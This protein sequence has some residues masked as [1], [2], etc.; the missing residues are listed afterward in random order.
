MK[1]LSVAEMVTAEAQ[2]NSAGISYA[3]MMENAGKAVAD[4]ILT[5]E[6][7]RHK[8]VTVLVGAGN[9]GGD[10]LVAARHL[11]QANVD[12]VC[13]LYKPRD[14]EQEPN[15][16]KILELNVP[17]FQF[18]SDQQLRRLHGRLLRTDIVVD[19]LLGTGVSRP[20]RGE[21]AQLF[22]QLQLSLAQRTQNLAEQSRPLLT[23]IAGISPSPTPKPIVVA[24][25]CPSGLNCDTGAIDP[26]TLPADITVTFAV[27]KRGH[28]RFP[29]AGSCGKLWV[30]DIGIDQQLPAIANNGLELMNADQ[31]KALLPARL[32]DGHKGSFGK[33]VIFAGQAQYWGAPVLAGL[34]ALRAGAGLVALGVP[35]SIRPTVA[36]QLPSATYPP[37]PNPYVLDST[38]VDWLIEN[39]LLATVDGLLVGPGLGEAGDFITELLTVP[40]LPPLVVDADGLNG[41]LRIEKWWQKLPANSVLTPHPGEMARL[42]GINRTEM[43]QLDRINLAQTKAKAWG[44]I[45]VLKGAYTVVAH[46]AGR[47]MLIPFANPALAIAGSGD[48]LAGIIVSLLAQGLSP[49]GSAI[50]GAFWHGCAG[51]LLSKQGGNAGNLPTEIAQLMPAVRR[52]WVT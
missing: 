30:A 5:F 12:V 43:A 31:A 17:A 27:P 26:L 49:F 23:P 11:A 33:V 24:V 9:N 45:V 4:L 20:I 36:I 1:I 2:A 41:L 25:D 52:K 14:P 28:F 18:S 42:C 48:V 46:P 29:G 39:D 10:G 6:E 13:Y 3:T 44:H 21:L 34:G 15:Y 51:E 22:R 35:A 37:I 16:A 8:K 7:I 32:A 19:A 40:N 50:L 38:D 47:T